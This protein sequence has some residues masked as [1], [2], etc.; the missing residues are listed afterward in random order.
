MNTKKAGIRKNRLI[1]QHA[2]PT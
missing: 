2:T 1:L